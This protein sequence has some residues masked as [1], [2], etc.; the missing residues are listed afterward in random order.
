VESPLSKYLRESHAWLVDEL[1]NFQFWLTA[2]AD[3]LLY[4]VCLLLDR[5]R[6]DAGAITE[7]SL[8]A[9]YSLTAGFPESVEEMG[10]IIIHQAIECVFFSKTLR[11]IALYNAIG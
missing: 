11:Y 3:L 8:E 7:A 1:D 5:F 6:E 4:T 2:L 10:W 9:L